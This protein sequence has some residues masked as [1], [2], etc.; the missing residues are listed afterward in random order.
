[1][2]RGASLLPLMLR[3]HD[4][5]GGPSDWPRAGSLPWSNARYQA[6]SLRTGHFLSLARHQ[7]GGLLS[8]GLLA[9]TN[10]I[11]GF[12]VQDFM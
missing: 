8:S 10:V 12:P 9:S 3:K 7:N 1:M 5:T 2:W 4:G 11:Q 6:T